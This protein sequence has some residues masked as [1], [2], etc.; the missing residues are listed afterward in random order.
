MH[1]CPEIWIAIRHAVVYYARAA[2]AFNAGIKCPY[3]TFTHL[4]SIQQKSLTIIE[5]REFQYWIIL[6]DCRLSGHLVSFL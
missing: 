4:A 6:I 1:Q 3:C 5:I 2:H